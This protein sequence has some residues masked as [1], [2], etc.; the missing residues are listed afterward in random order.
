MC[1]T[2]NSFLCYY[3][4][5]DVLVLLFI[6]LCYLVFSCCTFNQNNYVIFI[7]IQIYHIL[8]IDFF[9]PPLSL[10]PSLSPSLS[11]SLSPSLSLSL[12]PSLPSPPPSRASM[13][14]YHP[15]TVGHGGI[16]SLSQPGT[17]GNAQEG[18]MGMQMG[19]SHAQHGVEIGSSGILHMPPS[20][21]VCIYVH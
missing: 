9:L 15:S 2:I 6:V 5:S 10:P 12:S 14:T 4:W 3:L 18:A 1:V 21:S 11:S 13:I 19:G 7:G 16:Q 8:K 20:V 17:I